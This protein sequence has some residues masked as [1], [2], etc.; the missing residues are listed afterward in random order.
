M[1]NL[2]FGFGALLKL[3]KMTGKQPHEIF[4]S[5][6]SNP[7]L[8]VILDLYIAGRYNDNHDLTKDEA[9][10]EIDEAI[11]EVGFLEMSKTIGTAM[12]NSIVFQKK[13]E[14]EEKKAKK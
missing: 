2:E 6:G 5:Y 14:K 11:R 13:G 4:E 12:K 10:E 8:E 3:S 1:K 9:I 7:T